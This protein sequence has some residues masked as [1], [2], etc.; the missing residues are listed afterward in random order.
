LIGL[1][2]RVSEN[3]LQ[4]VCCPISSGGGGD[5]V[6]TNTPLPT[7]PI[8]R[9][10]RQLGVVSL[11]GGAVDVSDRCSRLLGQLCFGGLAIDPRIIRAL[12]NTDVV[13][14]DGS[15]GVPLAQL[16][17]TND[18]LTRP[19]GSQG[20]QLQQKAGTFDLLTDPV[21][22]ATRLL[23][24]TYGSQGQQL[25]QLGGTFELLTRPFGSQGQQLLQRALT[26]DLEVQ[27]RTAGVEYDARDRNWDLNFATDQVDV[28][29]SSV[30]VSSLAQFTPIQKALQHNI[31]LPAIG[32]DLLG[33]VLVP[34]NTPCSFRITIAVSISGQL[35]LDRINGGV[36]V[37]TF[38]NGGTALS[39]SVE[40]TFD[41]QVYAGDT[42]NLEYTV[43]GGNVM[44]LRIAEIDASVVSS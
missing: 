27:L 12:T 16:A 24:V 15:N 30:T 9:V 37:R 28:S 41:V 39:E 21:D 17:V 3:E 22:R 25:Q 26:F 8:D 1:P 6:V 43:T 14:V 29:G 44:I 18:L 34:T 5:V 36:E 4:R 38:L 35:K 7:D 31:A 11:S 23:G 19:F 42:I 10:G 33:A 40:Y 13:T 2:Y 20:Q 32:T